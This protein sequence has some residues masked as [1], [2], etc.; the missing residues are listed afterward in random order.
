MSTYR[1]YQEKELVINLEKAGQLKEKLAKENP[2]YF[3]YRNIKVN[4]VIDKRDFDELA[5]H[6][7][8]SIDLSG[9]KVVAYE[10]SKADMVPK[11]AFYGNTY[12]EQFQMP[13]GVRDGIQASLLD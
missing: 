11:Y 7:F 9:A 3:V 12:L 2:D 13:F 5:S 6:Y 10:D 4:G 1:N 8:K